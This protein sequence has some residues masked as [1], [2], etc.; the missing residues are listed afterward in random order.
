MKAQ[1]AAGTLDLSARYSQAKQRA[2]LQVMNKADNRP[3]IR[4]ASRE[5]TV[6]LKKQAVVS[7]EFMELWDKIKQKT[8]YRVQFDLDRLVEDCV[9]E[10]KE[11]P[12]I[13]PAN[14]TDKN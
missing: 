11:M 1:L 2:I 13:T 9:K 12:Q 3:V 8:T 6:K 10:I 4:D 7:P 14:R 5:V